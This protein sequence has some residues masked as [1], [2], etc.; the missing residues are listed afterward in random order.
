MRRDVAWKG[1]NAGSPKG[2]AGM[3]AR[4]NDPPGS[5]VVDVGNDEPMGTEV[6]SPVCSPVVC[7]SPANSNFV[8][9]R[10]F[11]PLSEPGMTPA[12]E[13]V[14]EPLIGVARALCGLARAIEMVA[15]QS[16]TRHRVS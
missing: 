5:P 16:A 1:P 3:F 8:L 9:S 6:K 7:A 2:K 11:A 10:R 13:R 4:S 15:A 14:I 12:D